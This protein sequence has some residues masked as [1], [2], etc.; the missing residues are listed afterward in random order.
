MHIRPYYSSGMEIDYAKVAEKNNYAAKV[1]ADDF[2]KFK[3]SVPQEHT[4]AGNM[5][6]HS[7]PNYERI[8][9]EGLL[10]YITRIEKIEDDDMSE[11]LIHIIEGIKNYIERSVKYL[12]S[13]N[14]AT[15]FETFQCSLSF[16]YL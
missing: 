14:A 10:S 15:L 2:A 11:G 13:V 1:F 8:L 3:S 12:E 6:T 4:V 5:Y 16:V 9:K 7:M